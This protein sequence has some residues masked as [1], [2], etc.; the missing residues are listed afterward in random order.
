M[1]NVARPAFVSERIT[2]APGSADIGTLSH[3]EPGL[4]RAFSWRGHRYEVSRQLSSSRDMG[5]DR[6]DVYVRRHY[7]ELETTDQLLMTVYFER[8]PSD[9]SKRKAWWLYTVAFPPAVIV[10]QRLRLRRWTY[11]DRTD[12]HAMVSDE[13]TMRHVHDGVP[14]SP[15]QADE[16][17]ASTI[18]H[19]AAGFGDWAIVSSAEGDILG[20]SGLTRLP[21]TGEI[22]LGYML[23]R[24]FWGAGYASEAARAVAQYALERLGLE[25]IVSM[26]RPDNAASVHVLEKLGMRELSP[27]THRGHVMR[28]FELRSTTREREAGT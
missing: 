12:F 5:S 8:N 27:T 11:A 23:R 22:E 24:P 20:E 4:P 16:A 14:L 21:E 18:E 1:E 26:V 10:T 25:R 9:R 3:G 2:P 7:Y 6:G 15:G 13:D 17:L 28:K 19:Y